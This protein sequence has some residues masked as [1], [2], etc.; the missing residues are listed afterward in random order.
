MYG[1]GSSVVKIEDKKS[2]SKT[3]VCSQPKIM[4]ET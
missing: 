4:Y 1:E 3:Y 2:E